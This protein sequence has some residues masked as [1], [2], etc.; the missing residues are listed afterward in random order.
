MTPST[1]RTAS[2]GVDGFDTAYRRLV[3]ARNDYEMLKSAGAPT[4]AVLRAC[5][6]LY[7]A[8]TDMAPYRRTVI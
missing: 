1:N 2:A 5:G 3:E 4:G 7:R 8:R 6:I